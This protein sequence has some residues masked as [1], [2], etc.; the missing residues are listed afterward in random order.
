MQTSWKRISVAVEDVDGRERHA[1]EV[2]GADPTGL[3]V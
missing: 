2:E 1:E 3:A